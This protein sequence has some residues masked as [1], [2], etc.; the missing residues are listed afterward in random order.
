MT[1]IFLKAGINPLNYMA[2]IPNYFLYNTT[3]IT[4]IAIPNNITNIG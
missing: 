3:D 4:Q 2:Y 1:H